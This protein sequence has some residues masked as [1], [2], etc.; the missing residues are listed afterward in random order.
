MRAIMDAPWCGGRR[1]HAASRVARHD[2]C[3]AGRYRRATTS[4]SMVHMAVNV[5][6]IQRISAADR[7]QIEAV[8]PAIRLTDAGGWYDG[9]I[10]EQ[11]PPAIAERWLPLNA[12]GAGTQAER[13]RLLAAAE[14]VLS[15]W[16]YPRDL[17]A[18]APKLK[19]LHQRPAGA[20]NLL[21]SDLW[22][23]D[24]TVTT[25]RGTASPLPI[26][27]YVVATI[28]HFAKGLHRAAVDREK[29]VFDFRAYKP[30]LLAGKTVCV[31]GAGGIGLECGR[32]CAGLG[33]R[34]IG[35]RRTRPTGPLPPGFSAIGGADDLDAFLPESDVVVIACQWTPETT[36]LF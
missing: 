28:L 12:T 11:W 8:D 9:E 1:H 23:S 18:R 19:W 24:V 7:S 25:S 30:I 16:P 32:L 6:A 2:D 15:G 29:G 14:V 35:T 10:R 22:N 36:N 21:Q 13:D 20:S 33:M 34:V 5:L 27:E 3:V 17:R 4:W 26:A 31:V